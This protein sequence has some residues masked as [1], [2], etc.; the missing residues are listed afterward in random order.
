MRVVYDRD[1]DPW[2]EIWPDQFVC[3]SRDELRSLVVEH[4]WAPSSSSEIEKDFGVY[5]MA[6]EGEL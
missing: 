3:V 2:A 4:C 6:E 1:G 5:P